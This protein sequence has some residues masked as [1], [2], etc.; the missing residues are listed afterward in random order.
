MRFLDGLTTARVRLR[1]P[2]REDAPRI[3]ERWTT[4]PEVARYVTWTPHASLAV[5]EQF[6]DACLRS[7]D[8][9]DYVVL[10]LERKDE[11]DA[12]GMLDAAKGRSGVTLGYV[13]ARDCWGQ[14]LMSEVVTA[15][16]HQ[17]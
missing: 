15:V 1:R 10:V 4:D 7:A 8:K 17:K 14:G 6:I 16:A 5:T 13:L 3:Y 11:G 12:V 9:E 2:V